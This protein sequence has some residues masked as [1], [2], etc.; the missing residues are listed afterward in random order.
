MKKDRGEIKGEFLLILLII[1]I[2]GFVAWFIITKKPLPFQK[3]KVVANTSQTQ[4]EVVPSENTNTVATQDE[5]NSD[6]SQTQTYKDF[7]VPSTIG[8]LQAYVEEGAKYR[9]LAR[10]RFFTIEL[11]QKGKIYITMTKEQQDL[12]EQYGIISS[13]YQVGLKL[14]EKNELTG[15]SGKVVDFKFGRFGDSTKDSALLILLEDG[16]V[17][18]TEFNNLVGNCSSEGKLR[19]LKR[20]IKL[21]NVVRVFDDDPESDSVVAIDE[22]NNIYDIGALLGY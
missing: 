3:T 21:Q 10:E 8:G 7:E 17:E 1:A 9:V 5:D 22:K 4:N 14:G 13:E 18:Y 12:L 11:T 16:T 20:I 2:I 6:S 19:D 15:T